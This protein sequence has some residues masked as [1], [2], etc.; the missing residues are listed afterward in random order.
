[1]NI[2]VPDPRTGPDWITEASL[3]ML[4]SLKLGG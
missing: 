1:M 3:G 4:G 2:P